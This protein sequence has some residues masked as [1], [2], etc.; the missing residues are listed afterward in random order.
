MQLFTTKI[1]DIQ[2]QI[3]VL[4]LRAAK[5]QDLENVTASSLANLKAVIANI[6]ADE[7]AIATLKSAIN[8]LFGYNE[9]LSDTKEDIA[10][11]APENDFV[12]QFDSKEQLKIFLEKLS[13]GKVEYERTE[14]VGLTVKVINILTPL[15][16]KTERSRSFNYK[17]D[18][19]LLLGL[20][21]DIENG[22]YSLTENLLTE[23]PLYKPE[24]NGQLTITTQD[25]PPEPDD[26]DSM[27]AYE[28]AHADW[29]EKY[30][31]LAKAV[32]ARQTTEGLN[33]DS[34]LDSQFKDVH[35]SNP[36]ICD[37][38]AQAIFM[39]QHLINSELITNCQI[40]DDE[41]AV[42]F[43]FKKVDSDSVGKLVYEFESSYTAKIDEEKSTIYG[44]TPQYFTQEEATAIRSTLCNSDLIGVCGV[45]KEGNGYTV[46][47]FYSEENYEAV[48]N[49]VASALKQWEVKQEETY[50]CGNCGNHFPDSA[51][52]S[53]KDT[54]VNCN[55][56]EENTND[57]EFCDQHES[58]TQTIHERE[59]RLPVMA[60]KV[61]QLVKENYHKVEVKDSKFIGYNPHQF[62]EIQLDKIIAEFNSRKPI[63]LSPTT[64]WD[65]Q[66]DVLYI[67]FKFKNTLKKW[68][69]HYNT[70]HEDAVVRNQP[71]DSRE[72][73][74]YLLTVLRSANVDHTE[75]MTQQGKFDF[76]LTPEENR[77]ALQNQEK[78]HVLIQKDTESETVEIESLDEALARKNY[79]HLVES[80][81]DSYIH[82]MSNKR[83]CIE[84]H[85]PPLLSFMAA[86]MGWL[87]VIH[88]GVVL[89][90]IYSNVEG[91]ELE[92]GEQ[93]ETRE[94]A[95]LAMLSSSLIAA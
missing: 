77:K 54:C 43:S 75:W 5:L 50:I 57:I 34:Q 95:A 85:K 91:W 24:I 1:N 13:V 29:A 70:A 60:V 22:A 83:G 49:V 47:Y 94:E 45:Q 51:M 68:A 9:Q 41:L 48:G 88:E 38:K 64:Q 71:D 55:K 17:E 59:L 63:Q 18:K 12:Y 36:Y 8:D 53:G 15:D 62:S 78:F 76:T 87:D 2:S 35:I 81:P 14:V 31:E 80:L 25:E 30:P 6:E 67:W 7:E 86:G 20:I 92:T 72:G 46:K 4:Q 27:N 74:K 23:E 39:Y 10:P 33:I 28:Q 93:F 11:S 56:N 3:E 66:T 61:A 58:N 65:S 90:Q 79:Q 89:G 84:S 21:S 19:D 44:K 42:E 82:L 52:V 69:K 32:A 26:F 16:V 73:Y 40:N 37:D